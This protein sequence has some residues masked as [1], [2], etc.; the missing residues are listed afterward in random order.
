MNKKVDKE[1]DDI[2]SLAA[3]LCQMP[4]SLITL[5]END[6]TYF[7]SRFGLK[8]EKFSTEYSFCKQALEE[9]HEVLVVEDARLDERFKN[10]PF[11][12]G[13]PYV[14]FYTGIPLFLPDGKT[15]GVLSVIDHVPRNL[16]DDQIKAL[17][18]LA[19]QIEKLFE[20]SQS[21]K[22][23]KKIKSR[24]L[25]ESERLSSIVRATHVG[26]WEWNVQTGEVDFNER[27]AEIIGYTLDELVPLSIDTWQNAI[28]PEDLE[29]SKQNINDCLAKKLEYCDVEYRMIHK[30][31]SVIWG[32][33][34]GRVIKW[35][36]EGK[37]LLVIGTHVDITAKVLAREGVKKT[38]DRFRVLVEN[39]AD[40]VAIIGAD[41]MPNYVSP[42][43]TRVLGYSEQE[44]LELNLFEIVHPDDLEG[45]SAKMIEV[46]ENPQR[47]IYGHTSRTKH[48]DGSWRYLEAT[49][50]NLLNDP[51]INGIVDNFRDVTEQVLAEQKLKS[52]EESY[53]TLF[54]S[55]PLPKWVYDL[56]T[57]QILDVNEQATVVY[58]FG[59]EE[60]LSMSIKDLTDK[61]GVEE[62]LAFHEGSFTEEKSIKLGVKRHFKKNG[63]VLLVDVNGFV[64]HFEGKR[65]MLVVC[66]DVTE[67][68]QYV[69]SLKSSEKKF[70]FAA[71]IAKLGYWRYE[72]KGSTLT[73]SDE[74]YNI[75]GRPKAD[76]GLI[77][78][79][80]AKTIHPNDR[81]DVLKK[82]ELSTKGVIDHDIAYRIVLPDGQIKWVQELGVLIKDK[83]DKPVVF[84]GAVQDI[85]KQRNEAQQLK[86]LQEII[87][88]T[89][90]SIVIT[91]AKPFDKSGAQILYVNEAFTTM[92]G[93]LPV[94]VIGK[95]ASIL[96]GAKT[97]EEQLKKLAQATQ[98]WEP[99]EITVVNY[100][101]NGE[102][103][104]NNL[105][106][107]PVA[108]DTGSYTHWVALTKDVTDQKN[109][110]LEKELINKIGKVFHQHNQL[111]EC[112]AE[113]SE[114]I[115]RF[116]DF[117]LVEIWLPAI[118]DKTI[119]CVA[120]Y[121]NSAIGDAF[122]EA[123]KHLKTLGLGQGVP[124]HVWKNKITEV[125]SIDEKHWPTKRKAAAKKTGIN[126]VIGIPIKHNEELIGVLLMGT[127]NLKSALPIY[128]GLF[129]KLE[130]AI[131]L[132][133]SRKKL[134]IELAQIFDFAPDMICMAGFDGYL[135]RIN[136][137][138][139]KLLGYSLEEMLSRPIRSFVHE[140]DRLATKE[141]QQEL[142]SGKNLANFENRYITKE[143][144]I[145]W[146][147]WT[148]T[149]MPEH[150]IVY[151]VARDVTDKKELLNLL[152]DAARL[153]R[154]GSWEIDLVNK[155][156]YW[157][158]L[159]Y[160]I[161]E[162]DE[163]FSPELEAILGF[164][165]KDYIDKIEELIEHCK[166]SG[167]T[168]D[169]EAPIVTAKGN[170]IWTRTIGQAEFHEGKC[171]RIF[172]SFQDIDER[173]KAEEEITEAYLEKN[174]ILESIGDGFFA[175]DKNWIVTYWNKQAELI[176]GRPRETI[177]GQNFWEYYAD[178]VNTD[179]Y[180]LYQRAMIHSTQVSFEEY[181]P[182]LNKWFE[183]SAYPS[184]KGLS[185]YFKDITHKKEIHIEVQKA[186]ERFEKATEATSDAIWDWDITGK[187]FVRGSGFKQLFGFDVKKSI[188][189]V[190][191]WDSY[192]HGDDL[193]EVKAG[194]KK[195]LEN[196]N[197]SR[198]EQEYR[199]IH[200]NGT[201]K[202]V[203]DRGVIIRDLQGKAVRM[204]GAV[205]DISYRKEHELQLLSLNESLKEYAHNLEVSNEQLEQ[206]AFI[207]SHDLQEPLRMIS[208]FL[209]QLERK[210]QNKLDE[211]AHQY[212]YFASDGAKRMKQI[213]LD[214]LEY[215]RAG[216]LVE[217]TE[218]VNL[219]ELLTEYKLLRRRLIDNMSANIIV[220]QL[221]VIN[222]FKAPLVQTIHCLLDNAIKYSKKGV[223]PEIHVSVVEKED[224]WLLAIKDNGIG[225]ESAFFEK[226]FVIFQRLHN[227]DEYDGT[228][229]GLSIAKK[230]VESWGGKIW[231][232]SFPDQGSTFYFTIA[233]SPLFN[234]MANLI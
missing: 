26:T 51:S 143:G 170:Q 53:R 214:L 135:K 171:V 164:F 97:D 21:Q 50:T 131:G 34:Y 208:S 157:S 75:W 229:I 47:P 177:I 180:R 213:I 95:T 119:N 167:K 150:G 39:G 216:K 5:I 174:S 123:S 226:I 93:Y 105:T 69:E 24:L 49:I 196:P 59:R 121:C 128:S 142:Y 126:T 9:P 166:A 228:G 224:D 1:F 61:I 91:E 88:K 85:T 10:N 210:Y 12:T 64:M 27:W 136:P 193:A 232:D 225:I 197:V 207:A 206:F 156:V 233:K 14:V 169:F 132:E 2:T 195:A 134:E 45:I 137:A 66:Q 100:R 118:D 41:G 58:G 15:I 159:I 29:L 20:L 18:I 4:I 116:G 151:S 204:V 68:E 52:S 3:I 188:S 8:A 155:S 77:M 81:D 83:D 92:T 147:S 90:D 153:A 56:S 62:L 165:D 205:A 190:E 158:P 191:F 23:L 94:E 144:K 101:K 189:E 37:P 40:A 227:R 33:H 198:W 211:K 187:T 215:S 111:T 72:F 138:G 220:E 89:T 42:S 28:H 222:A 148:A 103:F 44:A 218:F 108:D 104:W 192:F 183:T 186:N 114:H 122:Y 124:G 152:D 65:C 112:L 78:E 149:A 181:Y 54:H 19:N 117:D 74:V 173:V 98:N 17:S 96:H 161:H 182:T 223:P 70:S 146:L 109:K 160:K 32:N 172:G 217:A 140:S 154:I 107:S 99:C 209:G 141:K 43:I 73:W 221:P 80:F 203:S 87:T 57:F 129:Q 179:F 113:V 25:R 13:D 145:V 76:F 102:E 55:S 30:N 185:V 46:L 22:D 106:I 178:A 7:K 38:E 84:E 200:K 234:K 82:R 11:T 163:G 36:E 219:S 199:I 230:N 79:N 60:F 184:E 201:I 133:L 212:I 63:E 35:T 130:T 115:A 48:K 168:F 67:R 16:A 139:L 162:V 6:Y 194:L 127:K 175:V 120:S 86:M 71:S 231:L 125:W 110:E 31:G 176:L 202:T